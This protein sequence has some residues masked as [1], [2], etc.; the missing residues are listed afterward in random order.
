MAGY[1]IDLDCIPNGLELTES[2]LK[3]SLNFLDENDIKLNRYYLLL[4]QLNIKNYNINQAIYYFEKY[5]IVM[6]QLSPNATTDEDNDISGLEKVLD[7]L[8]KTNEEL[9]KKHNYVK[10][11]EGIKKAFDELIHKFVYQIG[12]NSNRNN[13]QKEG[14]KPMDPNEI[15]ML[16]MLMRNGLIQ[17]L[18]YPSS[19]NSQVPYNLLNNQNFIQSENLQNILESMQGKRQAKK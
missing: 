10:G 12:L 19:I 7:G 4:A 9:K 15:Q 8:K 13:I 3:I 2:S 14:N 1:Y 17:P 16:D 6:K 18:D 11:K 5:T